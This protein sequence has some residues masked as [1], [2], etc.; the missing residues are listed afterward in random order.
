LS[1]AR[2]VWHADARARIRRDAVPAGQAHVSGTE[3]ALARHARGQDPDRGSPQVS[4]PVAVAGYLA[5]YRQAAEPA[6]IHSGPPTDQSGTLA[7][8]SASPSSRLGV[9]V[10][11]ADC[12][13]SPLTSRR[14]AA[15]RVRHARSVILLPGAG[16]WSRTG[17]RAGQRRGG[18]RTGPRQYGPSSPAGS[19]PSRASA[20]SASGGHPAGR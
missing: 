20:A 18:Q 5:R 7:C 2:R 6:Q 9:V 12:L 10:S 4:R 19:R 16:S 14:S 11:I 3:P 1:S 13:P 17:R 15:D 8:R